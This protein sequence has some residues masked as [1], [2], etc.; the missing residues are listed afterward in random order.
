MTEKNSFFLKEWLYLR[1]FFLNILTQKDP[2]ILN[3]FSHERD[4]SKEEELK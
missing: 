2:E 4:F 3:E 1:L